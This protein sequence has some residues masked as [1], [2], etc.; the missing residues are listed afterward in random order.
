[1]YRR[2]GIPT[3]QVGFFGVRNV[4]GE[5]RA[6]LLTRALDDWTDLDTSLRDWPSLAAEKQLA[7]LQACG[8]LARRL[9][10]AGQR[11]GC[12]YPNHLWST[13]RA[14]VYDACLIDLEKTRPWRL[15]KRGRMTVVASL[16]R[17]IN[18]WGEGDVR[19]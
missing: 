2:L 3:L 19:E 4:A 9:H 8:E 5:K 1:L 13:G 6:I 14:G 17:R 10:G 18:V 16:L 15:G 12:F 7:I 11:H